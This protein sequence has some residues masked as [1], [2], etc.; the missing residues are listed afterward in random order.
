MLACCIY[1]LTSVSLWA[2]E[3][4][5]SEPYDTLVLTEKFKGER[6]QIFPIDPAIVADKSKPLRVR[7]LEFPEK[8]YEVDHKDIARV[9]QFTEIVVTKANELIA[10]KDFDRAYWHLAFLRE[11]YPNAK[12]LGKSISDLLYQDCLLYTSPSPRDATLSRMPSSA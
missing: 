1:A 9:I 12:G 10:A 5:D 7:L 6:F 4:Y 11:E 2:D 8:F 3:I